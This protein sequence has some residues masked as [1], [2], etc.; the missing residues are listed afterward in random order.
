MKTPHIVSMIAAIGG[1][2]VH[3]VL[4]TGLWHQA[5]HVEGHS[6]RRRRRGDGAMSPWDKSGAARPETGRR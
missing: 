5:L 4:P 6:A 2:L 3:L 1:V